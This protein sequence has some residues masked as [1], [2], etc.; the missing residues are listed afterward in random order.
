MHFDQRGVNRVN[1]LL[2]VSDKTRKKN[3]FKFSTSIQSNPMN[4]NNALKTKLICYQTK[5]LKFNIPTMG[6]SS[7]RPLL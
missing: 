3:Y 1:K 4:F 5:S 7:E 6:E 2:H